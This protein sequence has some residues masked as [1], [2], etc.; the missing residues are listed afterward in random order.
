MNTASLNKLKECDKRLVQLIMRVDEFYPVQVIC[1]YR[2][3]ADQ[4]KAFAEKKSKLKFPESK[5]NKKPSLAVDIVPDPDRSPKTIAWTDL[6]EFEIMCL[7]VEAA[8]DELDIKIRL[9]R[10][11]SFADWPHLELIT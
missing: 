2:K 5:H 1:G 7:A 9:G 10:D 3:E 11:F 8:A 4:N 6:K